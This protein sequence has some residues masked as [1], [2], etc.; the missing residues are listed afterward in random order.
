VLKTMTDAESALSDFAKRAGQLYSLPAAALQVLELTKQ[1]QVD[2][3]AL[4][5]CIGNDPALASKVLRVVNSALF[6]LGREVSDLNQALTLLGIKPLKLL[7]LGFSLSEMASDKLTGKFMCRYWR[8]TLTKAAAARELSES[9]WRL[10]GDEPFLVALL[11][12]LGMLVLLQDVGEPF[13]EFLEQTWSTDHNL[14]RLE[15]RAFGFDHRELTS[16]LLELWGLPES[17]VA[18]VLADRPENSHADLTAAQRALPHTLRL[19]ELLADLLVEQR[20]AAL[21][22]L[23]ATE[24]P[25]PLSS[26]QLHGLCE[27]LQ[28]KVDALVDVFSLELP[29]GLDYR[30]VLAQAHAQ[31]A[32]VAEDVA[33]ELFVPGSPPARGPVDVESKLLNQIQSMAAALAAV[34]GAALP[35]QAPGAVP[36]PAPSARRSSPSSRPAPAARSAVYQTVDTAVDADP[37]L[38]SWLTNAVVACRQARLPLSLALVELDGYQRL[39]REQGLL[40]MEKLVQRLGD[41]CRSLEAPSMVCLQI[42][43]ARFAIVLPGW[44][45]HQASEFSNELLPCVRKILVEEP[46]GQLTPM[47]VSVGLATVTLPPKNFA[48]LSLL[49]SAARCL[50]AAQRSGGNTLKSIGIY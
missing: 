10:P 4:K 17:L 8:H 38:L 13:A 50:A 11:Q 21:A 19:A 35:E 42:R 27:R 3:R 36:L 7:V 40:Q 25:H 6:G 48:P 1:P 26:E 12:D 28:E 45:R 37:D 33:R 20:P 29:R 43:Q 14:A 49:E 24:S 39:A 9:L 47:A 16:R 2:I 23:L 30:D 34:T 31:W 41:V 46:D 32:D 18:G 44:G 22:R 5:E 15:K